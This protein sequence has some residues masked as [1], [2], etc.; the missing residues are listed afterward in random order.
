M[1]YASDNRLYP[2]LSQLDQLDPVLRQIDPL[3]FRDLM[4]IDFKYHSNRQL[5]VRKV[6]VTENILANVMIKKC[7]TSQKKH[8]VETFNQYH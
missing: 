3:Q 6:V 1:N 4:Q 2:V 7:M 5:K 8:V